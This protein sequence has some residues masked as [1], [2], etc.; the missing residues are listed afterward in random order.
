MNDWADWARAARR[1]EGL[2]KQIDADADADAD[3]D[4][5]EA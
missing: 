1:G 3:A 5:P 4:V 2:Q